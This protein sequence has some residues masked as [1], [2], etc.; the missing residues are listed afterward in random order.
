MDHSAWLA[1]GSDSWICGSSLLSIF[2]GHR[3]S[4][5]S[6]SLALLLATMVAFLNT[7][8]S[9]I[10][11]VFFAAGKP[12]LHRRAVAAS[13]IVMVLAI[14]PAYKLGGMAGGQLAAVAAI[15]ASYILQVLR[16]RKVTDLNLLAYGQAFVPA[17]LVS[18]GILLVGVVMHAFGLFVNRQ[19]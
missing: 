1:T 11:N 19:R 3:Y 13:A 16:V 7:L 4:D 8:N 10:T 14:Y 15:S 18:G 12:A 2:Y 9:L 6:A 5:T 17:L